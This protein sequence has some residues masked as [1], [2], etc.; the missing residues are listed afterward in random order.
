MG[1]YLFM[2]SKREPMFLYTFKYSFFTDKVR[3]KEV[4][5]VS[6]LNSAV[7]VLR[8]QSPT[9]PLNVVFITGDSYFAP[10]ICEYKKRQHN[11][12]VVMPSLAIKKGIL[13]A[14]AD[15]IW[16]STNFFDGHE[17]LYKKINLTYNNFYC[18][19]KIR[20]PWEL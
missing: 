15:V 14:S 12:I 17:P 6:L 7:S 13:S 19:N 4:A 1:P 11:V 16:S 2:E 9:S 8:N 20:K 10:L 5:D 18:N 3:L